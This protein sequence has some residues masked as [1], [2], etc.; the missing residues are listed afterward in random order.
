MKK[1]SFWLS[2]LAG[3]VIAAVSIYGFSL[4]KARTGLPTDINAADVVRMDD[5][6]IEDPGD[7]EFLL[8]AKTPGE[9]VRLVVRKGGAEETIQARLIPFYSTVPFPLIYLFIGAFSLLLGTAVFLRRREDEKARIFYRLTVV[10]FAV[11]VIN[12]EFY[13]L[14]LHNPWTYLP[15]LLF[16]FFYPVVPGLLFRFC[17]SFAGKISPIR[18]LVIYLPGF[19]LGAGFTVTF[20]LAVTKFSLPVFRIHRLGLYYFRF[21]LSAF[22]L[23]AVVRLVMIYR[24]SLLDREREQIKWVF[25]GLV[26]GLGPFIFFYQVPRI[27]RIAPL[28]SEDL[29]SAFFIF[30][31]MAFAFS[32]VR[33]KLMNVEFV[34]NRSVVYSLLTILIVSIYILS[35]QI[36]QHFLSG[37]FGMSENAVPVLSAVLAAL[38]FHPARR[39]V[40]GFVN[41]A[42]FRRSY[43]YRQ[44]ALSF[45]G[46]AQKTAAVDALSAIFMEHVRDV[47]PIE[48]LGVCVWTSG[49]G[50]RSLLAARGDCPADEALIGMGESAGLIPARRR[51]VSAEEKLDFGREKLLEDRNLEAVVPLSFKSADLAGYVAL[52]RKKSGE[53]FSRDDLELLQTMAGELS[54]NL[55]RI[56]LAEEVIYER[57]SKEKLDELNRLKTE[58][59]STVSHELRTPMSS[60]QGL[61]EVLQAGKIRDPQRRE[62]LLNLI[63]VESGRLS[64]LIHNIL[65]FGRMEQGA[66]AFNFERAD[67]RPVV[68]ET[69]ELFRPVLEAEKFRFGL[70]VPAGPV[71]LTIDRDAVKQALINLIDNAIKYSS[72]RKDI[73]L[74]VVER[75]DGVEIRVEDKGA[76]IPLAEQEKVF[77]R[78]YRA[79]DSGRLNPKGVGLGL[80]IV[81]QIM[82]AHKGSVRVA[83]RPGEG[84]VFSL[85]FPREGA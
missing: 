79:A 5:A 61:S 4:L 64:R 20:L 55:E 39:R 36:F 30:I 62:T 47:M 84:S 22:L 80:K 3:A 6:L 77:E 54:L 48:R 44:A 25:W 42:F 49:G 56:R 1:L 40:Q 7:F 35:V 38:A 8:T 67:V 28:F 34:I 13:C 23:L 53:R 32:I 70:S 85:V 72:E 11:V 52:G 57:A 43:D 73:G 12:G 69:L 59:I 41:K 51:A 63:V 81:R 83:S 15:G 31:P 9:S 76:G 33:F 68:E 50:G 60:I 24:K 27:L 14:R 75:P 46:E 74:E 16:V 37:V 65:D 21:Y 58:F 66:M 29:S 78:F 17:G 18:K 10:F 19:I 2:L 45:H 71:E 26:L 82:E